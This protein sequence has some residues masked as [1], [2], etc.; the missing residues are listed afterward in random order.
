[1]HRRI[2][3]AKLKM[4]GRSDNQ[5]LDAFVEANGTVVLAVS[6]G[7][8]GSAAPY[9]AFAFGLVF[10]FWAIRRYRNFRPTPAVPLGTTPCYRIIVVRLKR[11]FPTW[12]E[13][14]ENFH[15]AFRSR[16]Q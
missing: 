6:P 2:R 14:F 10:V 1:M 4:E 9:L 3:I 16:H 15:I 13:N 12:T 8:Y 7:P 11:I 5:V